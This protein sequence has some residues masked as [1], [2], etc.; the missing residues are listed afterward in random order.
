MVHRTPRKWHGS[1]HT[2]D[3]ALFIAHRTSRPRFALIP[4]PLSPA[5]PSY[6]SESSL[7][8][9][10]SFSLYLFH[11]FVFSLNCSLH[12]LALDLEILRDLRTVILTCHV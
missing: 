6:L 3:M 1:P 4:G 9:F 7:S 5:R 2:Q 11:N 8:L 10:L 12:S